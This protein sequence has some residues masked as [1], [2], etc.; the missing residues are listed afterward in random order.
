MTDSNEAALLAAAEAAIAASNSADTGEDAPVVIEHY[1]PR[2]IL[3]R[4]LGWSILGAEAAFL[5]NNILIV[6]MGMSGPRAIFS[7]DMSGLVPA[8]VY[9]VAIGLAVLY[10]LRTP[11]TALRWDARQV[12]RANMY[13]LRAVYFGVFFVGLADVTISFMRVENIFQ[14]LFGLSAE[15]FFSRPD[16]V[17]TYVHA[18]L[19]VLGFIVAWFSRSLGF[20]WLALLIIIAELTIVITRFVF[21][22]QQAFMDD[23]V[24]YWYAALFLLASAYTLYEEGHVRVDIFYSKFSARKKGRVNAFAAMILGIPTM[25]VIL[26]VG[27]DGKQSIINGPV[28]VFEVTQTGGLGMYVK[29]EMAVFLGIFAATM[30]IALISFFFEAVADARGEPGHRNTDNV[31]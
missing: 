7:G 18:P 17:G 9:V 10:V 2:A 20:V 16:M 23:L 4:L 8:L 13:I 27:F 21:S 12:H 24:R 22:Y 3:V 14:A 25:A 28:R 11:D 30:M 31:E 29:Y 5:I 15:H 26:E 19:F 1:G 6:W